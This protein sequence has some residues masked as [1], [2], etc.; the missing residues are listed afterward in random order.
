MTVCVDIYTNLSI[1]LERETHWL[2]GV[3]I[4]DHS[5]LWKLLKALATLFLFP[6]SSAEECN[7]FEERQTC[8]IR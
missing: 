3:R 7:P 2:S 6:S 5:G 8:G 1:V 4:N